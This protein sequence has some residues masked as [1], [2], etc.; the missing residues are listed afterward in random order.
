MV[1]LYSFKKTGCIQKVFFIEIADGDFGEASFLRLQ[2]LFMTSTNLIVI[3]KV[4]K[5]KKIAASLSEALPSW[6]CF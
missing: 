1:G 3:E 4:Q 5:K 6:Q 2:L